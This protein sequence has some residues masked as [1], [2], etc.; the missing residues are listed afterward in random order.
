MINL[1]LNKSE[2]EI[3]SGFPEYITF[4]TDVPSMVFYT[5]DGSIPDVDSMIAEGRV[6]LPL[7]QGSVKL[8][9][10]AVSDD[11]NSDILIEEFS[12]KLDINKTYN[13]GYEGIQILPV[14]STPVVSLSYDEDGY[15]SQS[16]AIVLEDLEIVASRTDYT[17]IPIIG[18]KEGI[19]SKSFINLIK[20]KNTYI[21][22]NKSSPN[23][24]NVYFDPKAKYIEI[25]GTTQDKIEGQIVKIVNRP[26]GNFDPTSKAYNEG[27]K[28]SENVITGNLVRSIYNPNTGL[29]VSFYYESKD[30][31]WIIS[32]QK[33]EKK[34]LKINFNYEKNHFVFRWVEDRYMTRIY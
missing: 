9:A 20:D 12:T 31:R 18:Q 8:T 26:Y 4:S 30:S 6:Y 17:G 23:D 22:P 19:T 7:N 21:N 15:A 3:L 24:N 11:D 28:Q 29:Y 14:D 13:T 5:L 27:P 33:T 34:I 2:V 25:D 32:K 10:V 16:S 1:T